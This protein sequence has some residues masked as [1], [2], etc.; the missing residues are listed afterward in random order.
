MVL[1]SIFIDQLELSP[2]NYNFLIKSDM[3]TLVDLLNNMQKLA[4][5]TKNNIF[6]TKLSL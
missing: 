4:N 5:T 6:I 2:K 1:K 3:Y